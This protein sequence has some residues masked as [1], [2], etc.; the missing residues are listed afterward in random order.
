MDKTIYILPKG[1]EIKILDCANSL[2]NRGQKGI[3][4][5]FIKEWDGYEVKVNETLT[6]FVS[7]E[8]IQQTS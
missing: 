1:T 4:E 8:D 5:R 2:V 7:R 6:V 3:I